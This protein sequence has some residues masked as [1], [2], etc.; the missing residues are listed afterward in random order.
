LGFD[1][2]I[3]EHIMGVAVRDT[4]IEMRMAVASTTANSRNRRPTMPP[5]MRMGIKTAIREMLME[6]T[7]KPISW[8]PL[9]DA[10]IGE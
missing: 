3:R 1:F 9:S 10:A 2:S 5:I 6:R 8:A 4:T 7:V